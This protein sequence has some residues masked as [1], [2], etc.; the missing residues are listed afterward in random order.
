[1]DLEQ[2]LHKIIFSVTHFKKMCLLMLRESESTQPTKG[3]T[4][5]IQLKDCD[6]MSKSQCYLQISAIMCK[7]IKS[8]RVGT[9]LKFFWWLLFTVYAFRLSFQK[10]M[11]DKLEKPTKDW[12]APKNSSKEIFYY[13]TRK[14][15][16]KVLNILFR[17]YVFRRHCRVQSFIKL[18]YLYF[19]KKCY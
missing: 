3:K 2:L 14:E 13:S 15:T 10:K 4:S 12:V 18:R 5:C 16:L 8:L 19:F 1:M 6:N 9:I 17:K 11:G 7:M